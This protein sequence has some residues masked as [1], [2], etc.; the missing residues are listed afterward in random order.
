LAAAL[1]EHCDGAWPPAPGSDK[2]AKVLHARYAR[3]R[4]ET[5]KNESSRLA[6]EGRPA[7]ADKARE[8]RALGEAVASLEAA[9]EDPKAAKRAQGLKEAASESR[10]VA[11]AAKTRLSEFDGADEAA[12]ERQ[13][14]VTRGTF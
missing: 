3:T 8:N 7:G 13:R 14:A 6:G 4:L 2:V 9:L 5:L 11:R 1:N 10:R 12:R